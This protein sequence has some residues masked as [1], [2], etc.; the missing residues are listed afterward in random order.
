MVEFLQFSI[1]KLISFVNRDNFLF[2]FSAYFSFFFFFQEYVRGGKSEHPCLIPDF[3]RQAFIFSRLSMMLAVC[4]LCMAFIILRY[5]PSLPNLLRDFCFPMKGCWVLLNA[6]SAYMIVWFFFILLKWCITFTD[7]MLNHPCIP[8][9][10]PTWTWCMSLLYTVE[11]GLL[12]FSWECL[13]LCSSEMSTVF[14]ILL[15]FNTIVIFS[16]LV[17]LSDFDIRLML[18]L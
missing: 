10:N 15:S 18:V 14:L 11:F 3:R 9:V 13:D 4:L 12:E 1:Y 6:F 16:L 7:L 2:H 8:G 17:F 5:L